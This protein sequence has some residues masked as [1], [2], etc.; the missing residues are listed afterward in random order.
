MKDT[1]RIISWTEKAGIQ[2]DRRYRS[3]WVQLLIV[4][5]NASFE[6]RIAI[7]NINNEPNL[8]RSRMVESAADRFLVEY[9]FLVI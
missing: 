6:V 8:F 2:Q 1:G 5:C 9:L 4:C 7:K 3:F